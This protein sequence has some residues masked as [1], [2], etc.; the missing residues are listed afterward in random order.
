MCGRVDAAEAD[1]RW[2][3]RGLRLQGNAHAGWQASENQCGGS[4]VRPGRCTWACTSTSRS[5]SPSHTPAP[6]LRRGRHAVRP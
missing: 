6:A 2:R 3:A 4:R 1:V 5:R